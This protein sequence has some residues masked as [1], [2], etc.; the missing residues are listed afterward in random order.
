MSEDLALSPSW[1]LWIARRL[2]DGEE[3]DRVAERMVEHGL[4]PAR[5]REEVYAIAAQA[6]TLA[7]RPFALASRLRRVHHRLA[8]RVDVRPGLD[9]DTL[10]H[11]YVAHSVP[12]LV[13]EF[14]AGWPAMTRWAPGLLRDRVGDALIEAVV[15]ADH[16]HRDR[17]F[18]KHTATLTFADYID[19]VEA[20]PPGNDLYMLANHH[21][22]S[23]P[24]VSLLDDVDAP[25]GLL[26]P[27]WRHHGASFWYGP[28]GTHTPTH[29]DT[30]NVVFC[31]IRG[32]KRLWLS[33][34]EDPRLSDA[35][36]GYYSPIALSDPK[37]T[38]GLCVLQVD[39]GPGDMLLIPGGWWHEV[40]ALETSVSL[41]IVGLAVPNRLEWYQPGFPLRGGR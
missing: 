10:L 29:H 37:D 2:H 16:P 12:V 1:Q 6:G 3:P 21:N 20:A 41:G 4:T 11:V 8:T 7:A 32:R 22:I 5:A 9:V 14:C 26:S 27:G 36:D 25:D 34:P 38:P 15:D 19:R 28:A 33:P 18:R 24:L 39:V 23:G 40:L 13:P 35:H 30:T 31:Q 17:A